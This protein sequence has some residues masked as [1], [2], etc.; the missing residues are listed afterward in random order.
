MLRALWSLLG[1]DELP[2]QFVPEDFYRAACDGTNDQEL[3]ISL[4]FREHRPGIS[5]HS[6]RLNR[7][8]SVWTRHHLDMF[9][10]IHYIAKSRLTS[11]GVITEHY[12]EDAHGNKVADE[13]SGEL[14]KL[15]SSMNPVL[16]LRDSRSISGLSEVTAGLDLTRMTFQICYRIALP[17]DNNILPKVCCHQN[18]CWI[19]TLSTFPAGLNTAS[20]TLSI[21][22][23]R[24][25]G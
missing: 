1:H 16:R 24:C 17:T 19:V 5:Q 22:R 20:E 8:A 4:T 18:T 10:R 23:A 21:S 7:L 6:H 9:H 13:N 3:T 2:Y 11:Q 15:L 25:M 14:V 12:F